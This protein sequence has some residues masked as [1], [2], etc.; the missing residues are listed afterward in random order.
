MPNEQID[1]QAQRRELE[2]EKHIDRVKKAA[3]EKSSKKKKPLEEVGEMGAQA[4][5][6]GTGHILKA[7]WLYLLPS[8][9]LTSLYINFHAIVAYLGGPFTKFFCKLGQ[10]WVPKVGKIGAKKLAPVGKGLE[11]GEVIVI[12]FM[13]IIIFLAI[14]ILVTIIYIITHPVETVRETIGL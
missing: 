8:L 4:T 7:A 1:E 10:E 5:Q 9:G 14:L 12:I 2:R 3:M 6:M 11:I 13:D